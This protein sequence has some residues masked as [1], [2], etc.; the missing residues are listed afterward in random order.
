MMV[1]GHNTGVQ[2]CLLAKTKTH[3]LSVEFYVHIWCSFKQWN[4]VKFKEHICVANS[5]ICYLKI[6]KQIE[7]FTFMSLSCC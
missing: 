5:E 2:L 3:S 1:G 7:H 6:L 4:L